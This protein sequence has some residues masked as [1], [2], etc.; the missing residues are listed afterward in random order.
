MQ[1][2]ELEGEILE[3]FARDLDD[4]GRKE[5][6]M[7]RNVHEG[8]RTD[9]YLHV[10]GWSPGAGGEEL[11]LRETWKAD[12]ETVFWDVGPATDA[13][14][15]KACYVLSPEGVSELVRGD[16]GGWRRRL[17]IEAPAF[18][19]TG[20]ED[21][22]LW[23]DF[24]RDWDG[25]GSEEA[26]LPLGV[27]ARFYEL[28]RG[29]GWEHSESVRLK[30]FSIY[31]NNMF[32]GRKVGSYQYLAILFYPLLEPAELNGDGKT[33]LLAIQHG[34]AFRFLRGEGGK[35]EREP[36]LWHLELRTEK[37]KIR[38]Q[39]TLSYRVADLNRDGLTDVVVHK[40]GVQ[41][42][43]WNAETAVFLGKPVVEE[44]PEPDQ[45]FPSRGLLSGISL[46]DLDGDGYDDLS[47]W[48]IRM[49]LWPLVEILLRKTVHL[50]AQ[51]FPAAWPGGFPEKPAHERSF[52]FKIDMKRQDFFLGLVPNAKG[53][54][55][56]D[57]RKDLVAGKDDDTFAIYLG[58]E[59]GGFAS[60][61]WAEFEGTGVNYIRIDDVDGD[62]RADL[63]GYR[64]EEGVSQFRLWLQ[65]DGG[66]KG[67]EGAEE[68][69][70]ARRAI[71]EE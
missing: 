32:F 57:G 29:K 31:N 9:R 30:P 24:M 40:V 43:Q 33:D 49:G 4:D 37:E 62:G 41:F 59:K 14:G 46:E 18:V 55:D 60:R 39:A 21:A 61:P 12:P 36:Q 53:D 5:I 47:L 34:C 19:S 26:M 17:R 51:F 66:A 35:L 28:R 44:W 54:F 1:Q 65:V 48:S 64:V 67:Q 16:R 27:E 3:V 15:R 22:L 6:L 7:S 42:T 10:C 58:K 68:A 23:L 13:P 38:K 52:D 70:S 2:V 20:Q 45:R 8:Y 25:D 69:P 50:E 11:V 71:S 63:Y 56:G